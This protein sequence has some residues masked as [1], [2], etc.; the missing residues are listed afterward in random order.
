MKIRDRVKELRRV[1]AGDLRP[2]PKNWRLH[3]KAQQ[4]VLRGVLSEIGYADA[5]LARELE[6]G[7]LQLIDGHL[8][9]ETT[10]EMQVPVLVLDVTEEEACK[11]LA[12]LDPLA[13]MAEADPERLAALIQEVST[14]SEAV[15]AM[16]ARLA[17]EAG[18]AINAAVVEDEVPEP[19]PVAVTR[20]GDLWLMGDTP[21]AKQHRLLCGDSTKA[22]DVD[23][24]MEG[25]KASLIATDPPYLVDYTGERPKHGD[26]ESGK[27]WS[28]TYREVDIKD[29]I[30]FFTAV[31][32]NVRR[33][34]AP[35]AAV[36]CWHAHR[37]CGLIQRVWEELGIL[38]HQQIIWVKPASVFGRV[39]WHFRH[40]PCMMGWIKGSQPVH[41]ND[42]TFDSV[43]EIGWERGGAGGAGAPGGGGGV[44]GAGGADV[45]AAAVGDAA[46]ALLGMGTNQKSRPGDNEHP[47]QKPVEIFARPMRRHTR[48][49]EV[50]FEPFS[51]SGTQLVAAEQLGR[52]CYAMELEPVFVDVAVR[53]WQ[54]L[55]GRD[56][57]LAGTKQTWAAVAKERG[58]KL[59]A[60]ESPAGKDRAAGSSDERK[61]GAKKAR[62][63]ARKRVGA[64]G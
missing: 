21:N 56:A 31:F 13:G 53:R 38:D 17:R 9:A 48:I 3:P 27:D 23:R 44:G 50:C 6:D 1:R 46:A 7:S 5:L 35:K 64:G 24:L 25:A 61:K 47:T 4:E 51:G 30:G 40:E 49:T 28:A 39:Y 10:P 2:H 32:D 11:L 19:L 59:P 16:L 62:V 15:E 20:A 57:V 29:A 12:T 58:V 60:A 45:E 18:V 14:G 36:Y 22:E 26:R 52:R 33:V 63:P 54:R 55:T 8:R 42:H 43:W 41:N 37:R 34:A